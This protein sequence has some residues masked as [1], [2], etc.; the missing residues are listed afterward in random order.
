[1]NHEALIAQPDDLI[2]VTGATGFIGSRVVERLLDRGFRNIRCL[3]RPTGDPSKLAALAGRA[4]G[5]VHVFQG[6]LLSREDC[7]AASAGAAIVFH[8]AAA[9]GE[10][11]FPDAFMNSVVT[12][13]NLLDA[14]RRHACLRRFVNVSS[15]TV[16]GA[17]RRAGSRLLDE[18]CPV[19]D[20]PE[21]R[22]DAYCFAKV[23]QDQLVT[24]YRE[25]FGIPCVIVRPGYVFG[26]GNEAIT[27]RVGIGTF[28]IFLHLGG[29]NTLPLT[30][31][32]NCAEAIVLAGL[33]QGVDG[34]VFNVVDDDLPS[35]RQF[36]NLYKRHVRGFR[37]IYVPH[38]ASYALCWLWET[39]SNWSEG[40]LPPVFNRRSWQAYWGKTRY[41][42]EKL[43]TRLGWMPSVPTSEALR[44]Y[45]QS[46]RTKVQHA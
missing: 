44:R 27:G 31:V 41:T 37:S 6:N 19:E 46:C 40:Q 26:P 43:K 25:T 2:L 34:E 23:K 1:M 30:Y 15:F 4:A 32:D 20:R 14:V 13:R 38:A 12:T 45:F 11:S 7:S 5:R 21:L 18:S 24:E 42:N 17:G 33:K 36:L 22:G 10:K 8:L 29:P 9:R 28:G 16:Y 3:V 35:S 39:Y